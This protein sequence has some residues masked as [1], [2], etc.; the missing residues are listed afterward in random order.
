MTP[1]DSSNSSFSKRVPVQMPLRTKQDVSNADATQMEILKV[2]GEDHDFG[3]YNQ[4]LW[5]GRAYEEF[6]DPKDVDFPNFDP[7]N[8]QQLGDRVKS[9]KMRLRD[10]AKRGNGKLDLRLRDTNYKNGMIFR[11]PD[12]A[13]G[14]DADHL[15]EAEI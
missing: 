15:S 6:V 10:N 1:E 13:T 3:E 9:L 7:N 8:N 11:K 2:L 5:K 14:A 12:E 4:Q